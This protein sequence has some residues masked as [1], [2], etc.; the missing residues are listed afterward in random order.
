MKEIT[1][2][3]GCGKI[4]DESDFLDCCQDFSCFEKMYCLDPPDIVFEPIEC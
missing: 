2:C 3:K 1:Y 4:L